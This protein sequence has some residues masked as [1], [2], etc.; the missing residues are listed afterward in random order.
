MA[1]GLFQTN[2][3]LSAL[4]SDHKVSLNFTG[5]NNEQTKV[6]CTCGKNCGT[7]KTGTSIPEILIIHREHLRTPKC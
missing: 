7:V 4:K 5:S 3:A 1:D 2:R 6:N